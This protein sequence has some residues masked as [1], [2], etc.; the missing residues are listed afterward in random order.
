MEIVGGASFILYVFWPAEVEVRW[1]GE[2]VDIWD[3]AA[4]KPVASAP[5]ASEGDMHTLAIEDGPEDDPEPILEGD[6]ACPEADPSWLR[7]MDAAVQ[8][9]AEREEPT[10]IHNLWSPTCML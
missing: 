1:F 6:I 5:P 7:N 9:W 2:T 10:F 3:P 8:Y 4:P